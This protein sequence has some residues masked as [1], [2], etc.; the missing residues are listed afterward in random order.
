MSPRFS[1]AVVARDE[2]HALPRLLASLSS[3]RQ[4]GGDLLLLDTGSSD[5]TVAVARES[6]C[7][8]VEAGE[9]FAATLSASQADEIERRFA[10]A[11]EGPL[12]Q[13]GERTFHFAAARNFA[14]DEA[15]RDVV[16]QVDAGDEVLALDLERIDA[17]LAGGAEAFEYEQHYGGTVLQI[18]RFADRSRYRWEGRVHEIL[19]R[20]PGYPGGARVRCGEAE[21]LVRHNKDENKQR[22]YLAG[23]ALQVLE[24]PAAP[25]W[26]HYLGRELLYRGYH[27]SAIEPLERHAAAVEA[28]QPERSQSLC[29]AGQCHEAFAEL[30]EAARVYRRAHEI[31]PSRREPLLRLATLAC[32]RGEFDAAVQWARAALALP[33]TCAYPELAANYTWRP[34]SLLYWSLF[35]LGRREEAQEH[36]RAYLASCPEAEVVCEHARLFQARPAAPVR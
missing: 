22:P 29:F 18:A 17:Q 23:L 24:A 21:L 16:L 30:D 4:R 28:W 5:T 32:G 27:R 10:R 36:W 31:D 12:V 34:H 11:G 15:G 7:R 25:R 19:N 1:I 3:F 33:R 14:A 20:A 6:G 35:W 8:V 2:A 26:W 13:A 9:R